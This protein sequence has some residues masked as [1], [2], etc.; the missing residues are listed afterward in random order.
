MSTKIQ[1]QIFLTNYSIF[2]KSFSE[3]R[4]HENVALKWDLAK[5]DRYNPWKLTTELGDGNNVL[6]LFTAL[7]D[8]RNEDNA[9]LKLLLIQ[10][11]CARLIHESKITSNHLIT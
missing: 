5:R 9:N 10:C 7:A 11:C 1:I 4:V 3:N 6:C 8:D 2:I